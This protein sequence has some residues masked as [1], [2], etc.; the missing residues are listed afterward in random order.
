MNSNNNNIT[1]NINNMFAHDVTFQCL[2][3]VMTSRARQLL[4]KSM[5]NIPLGLQQQPQQLQQQQQQQQNNNN[6][7]DLVRDIFAENRCATI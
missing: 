5:N 6:V 4:F 2:L 3:Y 1:N 7:H